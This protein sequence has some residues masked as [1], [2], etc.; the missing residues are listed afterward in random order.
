MQVGEAL[1]S[2]DMEG[3]GS[4][5]E[6]VSTRSQD[7]ATSSG[8]PAADTSIPADTQVTVVCTFEAHFQYNLSL[9]IWFMVEN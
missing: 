5:A 7:F 3:D 6:A 1:L 9:F 2:I 8:M 4:E